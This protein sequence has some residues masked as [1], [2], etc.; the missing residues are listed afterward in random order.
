MARRRTRQR[1][2]NCGSDHQLGGGRRRKT[3]QRGGNPLED[4]GIKTGGRR[5][6]KSRTRRK[7][8]GGGTYTEGQSCTWKTFG[9]ECA[10]NLSCKSGQCQPKS[11]STGPSAHTASTAG[12]FLSRMPSLWGGSKRRRRRRTKRRRSRGRKRRTK[13]RRR[14]R[15]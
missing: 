4:L 12:S 2:G 11:A 3:R 1:G 6:R 13:K 9:S 7:R 15:R 14:R 5:R 8:K 10:D